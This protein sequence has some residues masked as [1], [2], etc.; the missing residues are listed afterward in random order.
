MT[1]THHVPDLTADPGD[2][3]Y[4][5]YLDDVD[6]SA[7][8]WN[9]IVLE[10]LI[11][12]HPEVQEELT[13]VLS[14]VK[15]EIEQLKRAFDSDA[16]GETTNIPSSPTWTTGS[17]G[18]DDFDPGNVAASIDD[19]NG[20]HNLSGD[21]DFGFV[22]VL[23]TDA[24]EYRTLWICDHEHPTITEA[25]SCAVWEL[26]RR[27]ADRGPWYQEIIEIMSDEVIRVK[28]VPWCQAART[29]TRS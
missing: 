20:A 28:M 14:L 1:N 12:H 25:Q 3:V 27:I 9:A 19:Y 13:L 24:P 29:Q 11:A 15:D 21:R 16:S 7:M 10:R 22:G 26:R 4:G 18:C 5:D 6:T 17:R 8:N 2:T 23:D